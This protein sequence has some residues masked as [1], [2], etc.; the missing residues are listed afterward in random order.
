M[1]EDRIWEWLLKATDVGL[2]LSIAALFGGLIV[3]VLE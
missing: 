3:K 1:N 2:V